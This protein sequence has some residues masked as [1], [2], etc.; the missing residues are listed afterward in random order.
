M[1]V[2][3]LASTTVFGCHKKTPEEHFR[4]TVEGLLLLSSSD[5]SCKKDG[6]NTVCHPNPTE[7]ESGKIYDPHVSISPS[8]SSARAVDFTLNNA[9]PSTLA[10]D[11]GIDQ[12]F[13]VAA[14]G[15]A[16]DETTTCYR[17]NSGALKGC[18][19]C[20]QHREVGLMSFDHKITVWTADGVSAGLGLGLAVDELKARGYP[21]D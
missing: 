18:Y 11:G 21:K 14:Q 2:A 16:K 6:S 4:D 19:A 10:P 9:L 8:K 12:L 13:T 7:W 15:P 5:P 3:V 17:L 20:D 1:I